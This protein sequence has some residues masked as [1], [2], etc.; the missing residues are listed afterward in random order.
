M[1][2]FKPNYY[3]LLGVP[4]TASSGEIK[5]AYRQKMKQAHPDLA[6]PGNLEDKRR[7][8][9][10]S[11]QLN[12][13]YA[14][15]SDDAH[16][17]SY[18]LYRNMRTQRPSYTTPPAGPSQ[19]QRPTTWTYQGNPYQRQQARPASPPPRPRPAEKQRPTINLWARGSLAVLIAVSLLSIAQVFNKGLIDAI[20]QNHLLSILELGILPSLLVGVLAALPL[21]RIGLGHKVR[22]LI[23]ARCL[24]VGMALHLGSAAY[25][26]ITGDFSYMSPFTQSSDTGKLK[27]FL[28]D[29]H[30]AAVVVTLVPILIMLLIVVGSLSPYLRIVFVS[31][32]R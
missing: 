19:W 20:V 21:L 31:H 5:R 29:P 4:Q 16:R 9:V 3:E 8:E 13:A 1:P 26:L 2:T 23:L 18:D 22:K 28:I 27:V 10:L 24:L 25:P 17:R 12:E 14:V 15:L 7:R 11:K 6:E 30:F 32:K